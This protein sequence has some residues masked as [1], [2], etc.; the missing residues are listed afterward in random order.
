MHNYIYWTVWHNEERKE[1]KVLTKSISIP[2]SIQHCTLHIPVDIRVN[3]HE[4]KVFKNQWKFP[5]VDWISE[6]DKRIFEVGE[7]RANN[8]NSNWKKNGMKI[9]WNW[10]DEVYVE[11]FPPKWDNLKI[12]LALNDFCKF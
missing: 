8:W 6:I 5:W 10:S 9:N 12:F 3:F 1:V 2:I 4:K 7:N 11:F